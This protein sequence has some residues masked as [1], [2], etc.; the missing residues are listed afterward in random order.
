MSSAS[1]GRTLFV[2]IGSPHGDDRIGWS[3][4]DSLQQPVR[5]NI[6]IRKATIPGDL[7]DWLDGV[8]RLF[9]CDACASSGASNA[10]A[11]AMHRWDWPTKAVTALRSANSHAFGLSQVLQLTQ[12]LGT[13]PED[14]TVIGIEG[15]SFDAFAELS[16]RLA[17]AIDQMVPKITEA[18]LC[19]DFHYA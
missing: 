17:A 15:Q 5:M 7:L 8:N 1:Q 19:E 3:I 10:D 6:D 16:P 11:P 13:L 18:I 4:A 14:V 9:V 2:G 12:R